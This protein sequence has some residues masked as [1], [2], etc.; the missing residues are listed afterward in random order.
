MDST[1]VQNISFTQYPQPLFE[2][3]KSYAFTTDWDDY[4]NVTEAINCE[5][6]F[7]A[8]GYNKVYTTAM[9]LDR[10]KNGIGRAR[11]LGIKE[12]DNRTCK[13]NTNT[14]PVNDII[15]N[16]DFIFFV[17]NILINILTFPILTLLFVAHLIA[18]LWPIIKV[19]LLFL[20]P[21]LIYQ[22]V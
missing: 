5:D 8:F 6:T 4:V 15:R 12:I 1:Q 20:G 2:L 19:L 16:F 11:H 9:F 13:S 3:Y 18:L 7:Y 22:G 14:F 17:F 21:Y 10:Y